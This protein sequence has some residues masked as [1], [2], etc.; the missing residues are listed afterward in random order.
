MKLLLVV[1]C[2]SYFLDVLPFACK[3]EQ[4]VEDSATL[5]YSYYDA[6]DP[7]VTILDQTHSTVD[8][9]PDGE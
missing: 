1:L 2:V 8:F 9:D 7:G 6:I 3:M 4:S 5:E